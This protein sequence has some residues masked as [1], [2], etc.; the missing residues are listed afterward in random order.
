MAF[1]AIIH[2][3]GQFVEEPRLH[4]VDVKENTVDA[5]SDRWS[6]F[7]SLDVV[8]ELGYTKGKF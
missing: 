1:K 4:Y 8:A 7:E 2:H 5:D 6:Y 3:S